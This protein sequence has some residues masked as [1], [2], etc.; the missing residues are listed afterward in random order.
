MAK[1][2]RT[3]NSPSHMYKNLWK[4]FKLPLVSSGSHLRS[5]LALPASRHLARPG[6][7]PEETVKLRYVHLGFDEFEFLLQ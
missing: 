3:L 5:C 6:G 2:R 1:L 7:A 4:E